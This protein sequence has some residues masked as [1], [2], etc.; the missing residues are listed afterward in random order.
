MH[1]Y[2]LL[3]LSDLPLLNKLEQFAILQME[4]CT[5]LVWVCNYIGT[6]ITFKDFSLYTTQLNFRVDV[7]LTQKSP[8][9]VT[10]FWNDAI[11]P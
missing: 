1:V 6:H 9:N 8:G 11:L 2:G 3:K 10:S 7:T 4:V 5:E